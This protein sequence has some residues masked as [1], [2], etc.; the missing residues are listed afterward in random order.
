MN[1][2]Q[3]VLELEKHVAELEKQVAAATTTD[4]KKVVSNALDEATEKLVELD[5]ISKAI[6]VS[7]DIVGVLLKHN[8]T[9][10]EARELMKGYHEA[11]NMAIQK[12]SRMLNQSLKTLELR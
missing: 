6:N 4:I 12:D 8:C 7:N 2:E 1:I 11:F 5:T 9:V 10:G 3:K